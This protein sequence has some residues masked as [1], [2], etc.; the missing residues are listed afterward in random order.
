[1]TSPKVKVFFSILGGYMEELQANCM[2]HL[3]RIVNIR[4]FNSQKAAQSLQEIYKQKVPK[5]TYPFVSK[6]P[7]NAFNKEKM[8]SFYMQTE[9]EQFR[10]LYPSFSIFNC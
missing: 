5:S 6:H 2:L 7:V 4:F 9:I 1:M 8:R 10:F 3:Y